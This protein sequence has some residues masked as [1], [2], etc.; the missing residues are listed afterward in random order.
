MIRASGPWYGAL[1][2]AFLTP[3]PTV[4]TLPAALTAMFEA[5]AAGL[6]DTDYADACPIATVALEVASSSE[7]LRQATADVFTDWITEGTRLIT[8]W[9]LSAADA[10]ALTVVVISALEGAF[11]LSRSLRSTEP[12]RAAGAGVGALAATVATT[13]LEQAVRDGAAG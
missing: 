4:Q 1:A 2:Y 7:P 9:G 12:L 8:A 5:A 11:V 10:R 6:E 13:Q 3:G